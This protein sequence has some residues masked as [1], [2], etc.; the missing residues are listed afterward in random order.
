MTKSQ[1]RTKATGEVFTPVELVN[2][3]LD[4]LPSD[5]TLPGKTVLDNSCG[6]EN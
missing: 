6:N 3:M 2:E 5:F 1:D 4:K